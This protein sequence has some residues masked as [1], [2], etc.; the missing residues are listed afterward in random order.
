M[1]RFVVLAFAALT[2][3][4][5]SLAKTTAVERAFQRQHR[6]ELSTQ[7]LMKNVRALALPKH[8]RRFI[9]TNELTDPEDDDL[10]G[11]DELD[12]QIAFVRPRLCERQKQIV[13]DDLDD[14]PLSDYVQIRLLVARAKAMQKY[15]NNQT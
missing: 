13:I 15:Y 7:T 1:M 11:P 8:Q 3:S 10:P 5:P 12:L 9:V 6:H 4:M 14:E 2:L